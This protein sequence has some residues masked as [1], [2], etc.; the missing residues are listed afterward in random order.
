[1]PDDL[2]EGRQFAP[3]GPQSVTVQEGIGTNPRGPR[4]PLPGLQTPRDAQNGSAGSVP[5]VPNLAR[6]EDWLKNTHPGYKEKAKRLRKTWMHY[7][8]DID[9]LRDP[10]VV[11]QLRQA[12][13]NDDHDE[14]IRLADYTSLLSMAVAGIRWRLMRLEDDKAK[15]TREWGAT[16]GDVKESGTTAS[17][18]WENADGAGTCYL[19]L[20][21]MADTRLILN[22]EVWA[23]L[24]GLP[25]KDGPVPTLRLI[26]SLAVVDY[27]TT[28]PSNPQWVKIRHHA[29]VRGDWTE[30]ADVRE[31]YTLYTTQGY[32]V[33]EMQKG[34]PGTG[35]R[36]KEAT[37]ITP[38][39][40]YGGTPEQPVPTTSSGV[41]R[42]FQY[43]NGAGEPM[44]PLWRTRIP[45][46]YHVGYS[47]ACK[48][49][50]YFNQ[51]TELDALLRRAC[52]PTLQFAGT[53][54]LLKKVAEARIEGTN[55]YQ[56]DPESKHEH[57]YMAPPAGPA[58]VRAKRL[59]QKKRDFLMV[60]Y[61]AF[62]GAT[63][64]RDR[65]TA[66]EIHSRDS[67]HAGSF[68]NAQATAMN[69][70]EMAFARRAEQFVAPDSPEAWGL[71]SIKRARD[72]RPLNSR[73]EIERD[74]QI[75]FGGPYGG[76]VP[77]TEDAFVD[78]LRYVYENE[79]LT[80]NEDQA[81]T[82]YREEGGSEG[83]SE[84]G[85]EPETQTETEEE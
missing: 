15:V 81:R 3:G 18:L 67:A 62:E 40:F 31:R 20:L 39:I 29:D 57:K 74:A 12:E 46:E 68:L 78:K 9:K 14:R 6:P 76:S 35:D 37:P 72:Y 47:L 66:T 80:F 64:G 17:R 85:P 22:E 54:D 63:S 61:T 75:F 26:E 60:A 5:R 1:M 83:G 55:L 51:E 30:E 2:Q 11:I 38:F 8:A 10:E 45:M 13:H 19:T 21:E 65:V 27:D 25:S 53:D 82:L 50:V 69:E 79:G 23:I 43:T 7:S 56:L 16:L 33:Y 32:I 49:E 52:F 44:L 4:F 77:L 36:K 84:G 58:E 73:E 42:L 59:D 34:K 24:E 28:R 48:N 71:F 70:F 41:P